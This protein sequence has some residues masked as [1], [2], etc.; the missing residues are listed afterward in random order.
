MTEV[1]RGNRVHYE[2]K[3]AGRVYKGEEI[4]LYKRPVPLPEA[5]VTIYYDSELPTVNAITDFHL[6][7][8]DALGPVPLTLLAST[9]V[10]F[11]ILILRH[12][13]QPER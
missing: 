8:I 11:A 4:P 13:A 6:R 10:M 2:F 12:S 1:G 7:S 5:K 9:G 3:L